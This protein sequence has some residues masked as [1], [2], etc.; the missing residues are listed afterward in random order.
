MVLRCVFLFI[1]NFL[2]HNGQTHLSGAGLHGQIMEKQDS[3]MQKLKQHLAV[4]ELWKAPQY[5]DPE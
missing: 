5:T 3:G 4:M 1:K 2:K